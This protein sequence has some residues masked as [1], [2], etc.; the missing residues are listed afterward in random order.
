MLHNLVVAGLTIVNLL[1]LN[2]VNI[3]GLLSFMASTI[4]K[5]KEENQQEFAY[6]AKEPIV[7]IR[8]NY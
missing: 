6:L 3:I 8:L 2:L 7:K 5:W 1:A 4:A